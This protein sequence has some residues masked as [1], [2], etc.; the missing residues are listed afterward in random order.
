MSIR[1]GEIDFISTVLGLDQL[2]ASA[3]EAVLGYD[4]PALPDDPCIIPEE[5]S[6][7]GELF[8]FM[9]AWF[10][11]KFVLYIEHFFSKKLLGKFRQPIPKAADGLSAQDKGFQ[12]TMEQLFQSEDD[13]TEVTCILAV[14]LHSHLHSFYNLHDESMRAQMFF[15]LG[16]DI[17]DGTQQPCTPFKPHINLSTSPTY[18]A[19]P[20]G[21]DSMKE[22]TLTACLNP[23]VMDKVPY[24]VH[25]N[26]FFGLYGSEALSKTASFLDPQQKGRD[27]M[28]IHPKPLS[29]HDQQELQH[30]NNT[31][32][33][34]LALMCPFGNP[35]E[36]QGT[37]LLNYDGK[38]GHMLSSPRVEPQV[39]KALAAKALSFL[40]RE[41]V[42]LE[43]L[44][45]DVTSIQDTISSLLASSGDGP[46]PLR[47]EI[48]Y[49]CHPTGFRDPDS[50]GSLIMKM[51]KEH[52]IRLSFL[53]KSGDTITW[54]Q[55][56]TMK[57]VGV[58]LYI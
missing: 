30:Y 36:N 16:G 3:K 48:G 35:L 1:V 2:S 11:N 22:V 27:L 50:L 6:G 39:V 5:F 13:T 29:Q 46:G 33:T 51:C 7:N 17:S 41:R 21:P 23:R 38:T 42:T 43:S 53:D 44:Q 45:Q 40:G 20:N 8:F 18:R 12:A 25:D 49:K 10:D 19:M 56:Q 32:T 52:Y 34:F 15:W 24:Q 58:C 31:G 9:R 47:V 57:E 55:T 14:A 37:Q 26:S 54:A 28:K 4:W